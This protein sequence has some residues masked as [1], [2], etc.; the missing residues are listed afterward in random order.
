MAF[1]SR[2]AAEEAQALLED[3]LAV[4]E[5][6][7]N[8]SKTKILE[9]PQPFDEAWTHELSTF[10]IRDA[11]SSST[12]TDLVALFSRAATLSQSATGPLK[13]ALFRSRAAKIEDPDIWGPFQNLVWS[14]VSGEPTTM[15]TALDVLAEKAKHI[16]LPVDEEGAAEVIEGLI[17]T[18]SPVRNA[19]E[20]AWS[21]W[22][23]V[24][25][26]VE[27]SSDVAQAVRELRTTWWRFLRYTPSRRDCSPLGLTTPIGKL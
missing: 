10:R 17:S 11:D 19:S 23:A 24:A 2:S 18:H 7:I 5:L 25:L 8:P 6:A 20:L 1:R 12:L 22:A 16:R 9:L 27:L 14:A 26:N 15:P 13:Y 4:Y 21:L 3:A